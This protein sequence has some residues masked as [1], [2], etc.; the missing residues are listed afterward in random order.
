MERTIDAQGNSEFPDTSQSVLAQHVGLSVLML[1]T[2]MESQSRKLDEADR[3][4]T[5]AVPLLAVKAETLAVK[6]DV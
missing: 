4:S 3:S 1:L 5:D 2:F 6:V